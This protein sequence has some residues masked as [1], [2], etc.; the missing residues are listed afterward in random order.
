MEFTGTPQE[1][2]DQVERLR[3]LNRRLEVRARNR[4]LTALLGLLGFAVTLFS[5]VVFHPGTRIPLTHPE[6]IA[7]A[8]SGVVALAGIV[9]FRLT[10]QQEARRL[11]L[12]AGLLS[13]WSSGQASLILDLS[14]L[15][16]ESYDQTWLKL[17]VDDLH[18]SVRRVG[19][20]W[21]HKSQ[22]QYRYQE[23]CEIVKTAP[24]PPMAPMPPNGRLASL[25]VQ[26]NEQETRILVQSPTTTLEAPDNL[27]AADLL[28][29][30]QRLA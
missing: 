29:L 6:R 2:G 13:F 14:P 17:Q 4:L 18:L 10:P 11:R 26:Q 28:G 15:E 25:S 3:G 16:S 21:L 8:V 9:A 19:T 20:S 12:T 1:L 23:T 30:L 7:L 22:R 27:E 5:H 24:V